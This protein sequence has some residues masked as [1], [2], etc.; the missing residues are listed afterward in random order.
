MRGGPEQC[1]QSERD[2]DYG[3]VP[4][5]FEFESG[6]VAGERASEERRGELVE[7]ERGEHFADPHSG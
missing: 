4:D 1:F 3:G 6:E 2:R 7:G 5:H